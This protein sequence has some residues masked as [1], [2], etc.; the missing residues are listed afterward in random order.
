MRL[1]VEAALVGGRLGPGDLE[2][3]GGC[4]AAAGLLAA[5]GR[6]IAAP[7]FVDL[8]V[9]GFAGVDFLGADSD[10][11][12]V[13]EMSVK[14]F[15]RIRFRRPPTTLSKLPWPRMRSCVSRVPSMLT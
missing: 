10:G 7:G 8:Q 1:G 3:V 9:N 13:K 4:V 5:G 6:G 12:A 14:M 11:Y 2:I 15:A